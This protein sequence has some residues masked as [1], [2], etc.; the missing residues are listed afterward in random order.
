MKNKMFG[1]VFTVIILVFLQGLL[2]AVRNYYLI[3]IGY[4]PFSSR[5]LILLYFVFSFILIK[6]ICDSFINYKG[7]DS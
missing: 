6:I 1:K 4:D 2:L 7:D 5:I 3:Y